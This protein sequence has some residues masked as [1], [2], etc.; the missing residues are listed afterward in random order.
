MTDQL[1]GYTMTSHTGWLINPTFRWSGPNTPRWRDWAKLYI[2]GFLIVL[3]AAL[4]AIG[5]NPRQALWPLL[6]HWCHAKQCS[7][8]WFGAND[9]CWLRIP[10]PGRL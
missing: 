7:L 10:N 5:T 4:T 1:Q 3:G 9:R 8:L 6:P 2:C